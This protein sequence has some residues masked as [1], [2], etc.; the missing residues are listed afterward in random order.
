MRKL[1]IL[2]IGTVGQPVII[3]KSSAGGEKVLCGLDKEYTELEQNSFVAAPGDSITYGTLIKTIPHSI[4][5]KKEIE[6]DSE[7][8]EKHYKKCIE[9]VIKHGNIHII[10]DH[11]GRGFVNSKAY[12]KYKDSIRIPILITNHGIELPG[13][14]KEH[15]NLIEIIKKGYPIYINA[16][17]KFH[18]EILEKTGIKIIET[19]PHGIPIENFEFRKERGNYLFSLGRICQQ[20]GQAIAVQIARQN[21]I[22]LILGG[23]IQEKDYFDKE[24]KPFLN[25]NIK[26]IGTLN[27]EEKIKVYKNS[28]AYLALVTE[29]ETFGLTLIE[30]MACG[31][32]VIA[33]DYGPM[34]E[35]IKNE[36]TGF[37][38]KREMKN[39]ELDLEKM[40]KKTKDAILNIGKISR[41][42]CRKN[43]EEN[44]T[45]QKQAER[46]LHLYQ[47]LISRNL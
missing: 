37:I 29:P 3:G 27:D 35:I 22:P 4:G 45:S 47:T 15:Q 36:K 23:S 1:N 20:K 19:I 39:G 18:K 33:F 2:Q 16:F 34:K 46:Y 41:E 9:F 38:I 26:F 11:P 14:E 21:K 28:L 31:T 24:I 17:T 30:S 42:E 10:H 8:Y 25:K 7:I 32:P 43:V 6:N 44:F 13:R 12:L 5:I 40:I